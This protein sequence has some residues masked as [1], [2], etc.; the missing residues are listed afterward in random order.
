MKKVLFINDSYVVRDVTHLFHEL[1]EVAI[2]AVLTA[3]EYKETDKMTLTA[4]KKADRAEYYS[5]SSLE[6]NSIKNW[7]EL[8]HLVELCDELV[9]VDEIACDFLFYK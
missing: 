5:V 8:K 3:I 6:S 9:C 1:S 2:R 7:R 4:N